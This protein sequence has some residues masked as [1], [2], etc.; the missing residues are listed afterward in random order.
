MGSK[1]E[2]EGNRPW[3][4]NTFLALEGIHLLEA[5]LQVGESFEKHLEKSAH[6][7]RMVELGY[8][9]SP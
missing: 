6:L 7:E 5:A 9:S 2:N 1:K 8:T 4:K 3:I